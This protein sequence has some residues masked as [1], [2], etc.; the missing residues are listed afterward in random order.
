MHARI[1]KTG[2]TMCLILNVKSLSA[3]LKPFAGPL[4]QSRSFDGITTES[5][6]SEDR[7]Y[8]SIFA[9]FSVFS[10]G[11]VDSTSSR[12]LF[13][14]DKTLAVIRVHLLGQPP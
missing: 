12:Q 8:Y 9:A 10:A 2:A 1:Q 4:R 14:F 7:D 11:S 13:K 3:E 5:I 6:S